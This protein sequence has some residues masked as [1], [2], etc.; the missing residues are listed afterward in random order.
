M[1]WKR[2]NPFIKQSQAIGVAQ[3][4]LDAIVLERRVIP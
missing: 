4:D 3:V 2:T 1:F